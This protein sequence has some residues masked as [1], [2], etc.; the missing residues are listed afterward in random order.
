MPSNQEVVISLSDIVNILKRNRKK[1][2]TSALVLGTFAAG[3]TLTEPVKYTAASTFSE[4]SAAHSGITTQ[5]NALLGQF[6]KEESEA[7]SAFKSERILSDVVKRLNLQANIL[8]KNKRLDSDSYLSRIYRNLISSYYQF[9]PTFYPVFADPASS[10]IALTSISY[11]Q[12]TPYGGINISFEDEEIFILKDKRNRIRGRLG[13]IIAT[14]NY[15]FKVEKQGNG[16]LKGRTFLIS[17]SSLNISAKRL[18][19]GVTA[20]ASVEDKSLINLT[21]TCCNRKESARVA[22]EIMHAYNDFLKSRQKS[23]AN[24]QVQYLQERQSGM[25][26]L[27]RSMMQEHATKISTDLLA[28][29]FPTAQSAMDFLASSQAQQQQR[30]MLIDLE[31]MMLQKAKDTGYSHYDN[32]TPHGDPGIINAI[33]REI[34]EL[35]K[36]HDNIQLTLQ[37]NN[38]S[39]DLSSFYVFMNE[40]NSI[41][42]DSDSAR[43][44]IAELDRGEI[45]S[46]QNT[47]VKNSKFLAA[48]WLQQLK[49]A[50]EAAKYADYSSMTEKNQNREYIRQQFSH[51]LNQ[52]VR[53]F[54]VH[55][56]IVQERMVRQQNPHVEYQGIELGAAR[57]LYMAQSKQIQDLEA[58]ALQHHFIIENI[59]KPDFEVG[60]LCNLLS[61]GVSQQMIQQISQLSLQVTDYHNRSGKEMERLK[62]EINV[63]KGFLTSHLKQASQLLV[64]KQKLLREKMHALQET[65]LALIQQQISLLEKQLADHIDNRIIDLDNEY[66]VITMHQRDLNKKMA[67]LPIKWSEE[68]VIKQQMDLNKNVAGEIS[69]LIE[70]KN[71]AT[72]LEV[73]RSAPMDIAVAPLKPKSPRLPLFIILGLFMGAFFSI[74]A[75]L[76][77]TLLHGVPISKENLLL[78]GYNFAG[79]VSRKNGQFHEKPLLDS[80]LETLRSIVSFLPRKNTCQT[81][82]I[83]ENTDVQIS[84]A[85]ASLLT[86][87]GFKVL[88]LDLAFDKPTTPTG[89][90]AYLEGKI[91]APIIDKE[92]GYSVIAAGGSS[93]YT[94]EKIAHKRF[95]DLLTQLKPNYDW[96]IAHTNAR[97]LSS[98]VKELRYHFDFA[99]LT[100]SDETQLEL[101]PVEECSNVIFV[102]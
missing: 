93:R 46:D 13:D 81:A 44:L 39:R 102:T 5:F 6:G 66:D 90:L 2:L 9:V 87:R 24:S 26:Q 53:L 65:T 16:K 97:A 22:N 1:I 62:E 77:R 56:D 35:N 28:F 50:D 11:E 100:I 7:A 86:Q 74:T 18:L 10:D 80:D 32:I 34:R 101:P 61:D 63:K 58:H 48:Q 52:M 27:V 67:T 96:I 91:D 23:I 54:D 95:Q 38:T 15:S 12:E 40:L 30:I 85:V 25:L 82:L 70:T 98:E 89:L 60:S 72:N 19:A 4:K 51:Y 20:K 33:L 41:K 73:N 71:L 78:S 31:K 42:K 64:L 59:Q 68:E 79:S 8:E 43:E 76:C 75:L 88:V 84:N 55:A 92:N 36:Q 94:A 69:R 57:E 47:L 14:P 21:Y 99:I 45:P 29:G 17:L 49:D 37:E 83:T 3:W